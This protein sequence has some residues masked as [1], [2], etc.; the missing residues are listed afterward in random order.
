MDRGVRGP[1]RYI[2]TS[3]NLG[4]RAIIKYLR[5]PLLDLVQKQRISW[6]DT[7][8]RGVALCNMALSA[9][10]FAETR[11]F[12]TARIEP[13]TQEGGGVAPCNTALSAAWISG[14]KLQTPRRFTAARLK[15]PAMPWGHAAIYGC[16]PIAQALSVMRMTS[17]AKVRL[18]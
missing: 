8:G 7:R 15:A 10:E 11:C 1:C 12:P 9:F 2:C 3:S 16:H 14:S 17:L 4:G 13:C 18:S 6:S 5:G